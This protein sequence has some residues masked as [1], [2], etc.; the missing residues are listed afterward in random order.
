MRPILILI[1]YVIK[2]GIESEMKI[3]IFRGVPLISVPKVPV[4]RARKRGEK[5][6]VD[7]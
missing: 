3:V 6:Q 2:I 4:L 7:Q 1:K 5:C